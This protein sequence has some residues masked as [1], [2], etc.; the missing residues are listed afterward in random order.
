MIFIINITGYPATEDDQ[1]SFIF[2]ILSYVNQVML[3]TH[4]AQSNLCF[5]KSMIISY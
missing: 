5:L 2:D 3:K 4:A 1:G